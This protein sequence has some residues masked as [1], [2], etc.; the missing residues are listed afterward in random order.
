MEILKQKILADAR[1]VKLKPNNGFI[2]LEPATGEV[3]HILENNIKLI[4]AKIIK[5]SMNGCLAKFF[6]LNYINIKLIDNRKLPAWLNCEIDNE[7]IKI[8]GTPNEQN[9]GNYVI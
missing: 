3:I 1:G 9:K 5:T 6:K 2:N 8:Y 7:I 4:T